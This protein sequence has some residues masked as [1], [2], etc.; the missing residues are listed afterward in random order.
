VTIKG[1]KG[2]ITVI[3]QDEEIHKV[4]QLF[5]RC[6]HCRPV[7]SV[8]MNTEDNVK[9]MVVTHTL[10]SCDCGFS[11]TPKFICRNF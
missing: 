7:G 2:V 9:I 5:M 4:S 3:D 10:V 1:R 6:N 11:S 8:H